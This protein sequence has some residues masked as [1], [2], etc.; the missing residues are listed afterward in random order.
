MSRCVAFITPGLIPLDSFTTFGVN[1]KLETK[2]PFGYFGTGLKYAIA[3]LLRN[4]CR[5]VMWRGISR[6]EFYIKRDDFRGK[7]FSFVQMKRQ[8]QRLLQLRRAF[9]TKLPFTTELGKNWELWQAFRE[10]ETNTRDEQGMTQLTEWPDDAR[11]EKANET[12]ILVYGEKFVDEFLDMD[13]HFL[14]GGKIAR[15]DAAVQVIDKPCK[16]IYY[17]GVRVMDLKDE[18]QFTYNILQ[19]MDLTEDRTIKYGYQVEQ[20]I[21]N[22][23]VTN[24]DPPF[25][26]KA[27][28]ND[29]WEGRHM[30]YAYAWSTPSQTFRDHGSSGSNPTLRK[31]LEEHDP[32]VATKTTI[33]MVIPR[34]EITQNELVDVCRVVGETLGIKDI[35]VT[36]MRT[37][38]NVDSDDLTVLNPY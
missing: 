8:T 17:R 20:L 18:A 9:H 12:L 5:I 33:Q 13:R 16:H 3:V 25:V 29:R 21:S 10:L 36:N 26:R 4:G 31:F 15:E 1:V 22:Y 32:T 27:T 7:E 38:E 28:H 19:A 34:P 37:Q 2:S 11:H 14:V 24:E 35:R 30:S 23:I 6:Y